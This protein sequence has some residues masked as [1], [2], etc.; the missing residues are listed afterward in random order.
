MTDQPTHER[1]PNP[2]RHDR[3]A[4]SRKQALKTAAGVAVG[5]AGLATLGAPAHAAG[6][7]RAASA[8]N[9]TISMWTTD[10]LYIQF[11]GARAKEW[12]RNYPQYK[13]T[14]N[15]LQLNYQEMFD[16]VLASL[17]AG[18]GAPDLIGLEINAFSRFMKGDIALKTLV[19]LTPR[20]GAQ[21]SEFV[22]ARWDPYI[23]KGRIY[24]VESALC[25]AGLYYRKD[26]LDAAG[27]KTP[28]DS[29]QD[30]LAAGRILKKQ[31][32]YICV[33]ERV[34]ST[35]LGPIVFMELFQQQGGHIFDADGRLTLN[36]PRAVRALEYLVNAAKE[37][38][39]WTAPDMFG[40]PTLA[41]IKTGKVATV[42]MPDWYGKQF[43]VPTMREL[44]GKWR[45]QN[46]PV[47]DKGGLRVSA[48]GGTGF[49]IPKQSKYVDLVWSLL[50][51]SYMTE[52]NQVKRF[53][54][55]GY[56]PTMKKAFNDLG[57]IDVADP[58]Y[59]GQKIGAV[60]ARVA[61]QMPAQYQ[62][63]YWAESLVALSNEYS[64]AMNGSKKPAQAIKDAT[65]AIAKVMKQGA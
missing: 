42:L 43:I 8:T 28:F 22:E 61:G 44:A 26:I 48:Y 11:F 32:K 4:I 54:E 21:R 56:F 45:I 6:P 49:G 13:F 7:A 37:G 3:R 20:I 17:A 36:D 29:Y 16:K 14:Y 38:L 39:F 55:I 24:G 40:A 9:V 46:L 10:H 41:G 58:Y 25:P 34:G 51:Y 65:A 50:R 60:Y 15:F 2:A 30:L 47:W 62:S 35:G 18:S 63:P 31:G 53:Q 27:I 12:E 57:V 23:F 64:N 33:A 5:A 52:K 19:D 1:E 59:G